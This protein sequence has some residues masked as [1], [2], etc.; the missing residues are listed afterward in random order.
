M[1]KYLIT[2]VLVYC[3][4]SSTNAQNFSII[5]GTTYKISKPVDASNWLISG[6][7]T[8]PS[9]IPGQPAVA[10]F[11][12]FGD[13]TFSFLPNGTHTFLNSPTRRGVIAKASGVYGGGG[14]PPSHAAAPN[15]PI[16][17][18]TAAY[19][20]MNILPTGKN[21]GVMPNIGSVVQKDTMIFVVTYKV[22]EGLPIKNLLLFFN[23]SVTNPTFKNVSF[24]STYSIGETI[25][26]VRTYKNEIETAILTPNANTVRSSQSQYGNSIFIT[27]L[28]KGSEYNIF[29]T[30][31]PNDNLIASDAS[32]T[33]IKAVL[34]D[35]ITIAPKSG[36]LPVVINQTEATDTLPI[37]ALS[38]D[39]NYITV[40]PVCMLL[41]KEDKQVKYHLHFQNTGVG[42]ASSVKVAIKMPEG[43]NIATD[44]SFRSG[45]AWY[46]LKNGI[47]INPPKANATGDSLIL[48][49]EKDGTAGRICTLD[50]MAATPT[51]LCDEGTIGDA[52]FTLKTKATSPDILLAQASIVF[53]NNDSTHSANAPII[54]NTAV[55]QFRQCCDCNKTCDPCKNKKRFWRWLFCKKC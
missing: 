22:D 7:I 18:S 45:T 27:N 8:E 42:A 21:I 54:T 41:P 4:C 17:P 40:E 47:A 28:K 20:S 55:T 48:E 1:K 31:I 53:F 26:F 50:G 5:S 6:S 51:C 15:S 16:I 11:V 38:H 49:F 35:S 25:N 29:I 33:K 23:D 9:A 52:W 36:S 32:N 3:F 43:V 44:I 39:P 46:K 10:C 30:L 34:F 14:R 37:L 19:A 13:G 12:E 24:N 2:I